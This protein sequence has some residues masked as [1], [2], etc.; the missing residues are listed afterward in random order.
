MGVLLWE[1]AGQSLVNGI[2]LL[3]GPVAHL[4]SLEYI[5]QKYGG[6]VQIPEAGKYDNLYCACTWPKTRLR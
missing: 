2:F 1:K 4:S 3:V 5:F 6:A